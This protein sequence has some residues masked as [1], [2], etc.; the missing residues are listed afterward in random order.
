[1]DKT[2]RINDCRTAKDRGNQINRWVRKNRPKGFVI[3][4]DEFS[5]MIHKGRLYKTNTF[6]GF[7]EEHIE[8]FLN[9][10]N[11]WRINEN[12]GN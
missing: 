3:L 7:R 1:M 5:T 6:V 2:D 12:K 8:G 9:H 10:I 11:K 4:D